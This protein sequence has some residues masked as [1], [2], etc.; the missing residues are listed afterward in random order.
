MYFLN[1]YF[2]SR[3]ATKRCRYSSKLSTSKE[4]Q[5]AL[6][7]YLFHSKAQGSNNI[8]LFK[9][10]TFS[11]LP[12]SQTLTSHEATQTSSLG[13]SKQLQPEGPNHQFTL[14][15]LRSGICQCPRYL[16]GVIA[17]PGHRGLIKQCEPVLSPERDYTTGFFFFF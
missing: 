7:Y 12:L 5:I 16:L 13:G 15:K 11:V 9:T 3:F 14:T 8:T 6:E 4:E 10:S 17:D 1:S 2:M